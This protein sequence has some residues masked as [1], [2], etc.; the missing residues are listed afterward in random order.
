MS[1]I[2]EELLR[3]DDLP[4]VVSDLQAALAD[5][6]RRR[7]EF[8]ESLDEKTY[9]EFINGEVVV[10]S[11][12]RLEHGEAEDALKFPL[13]RHA[14]RRKL[15]LVA[16]NKLVRLGRND[17]I[18]DLCFWPSEVAGS[19]AAKQS[20]YPPPTLVVEILSESTAAN[21]RGIKFRHYA[22]AG[23]REYWLID[24]DLR[25]IEQYVLGRNG[26][27]RLKVA[28]MAD[29]RIESVAIPGLVIEANAAFDADASDAA[30]D[31]LPR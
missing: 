14:R 2:V 31:E 11:P 18:P 21:D 5:E 6:A 15:G 10:H 24:L 1:A 3:R 25:R 29:Q 13:K 7:A 30:D 8:V 17:Y 19:F 12:E 4:D 27:Y 28:A 23:I 20:I 9:A 16:G 26:Q 22:A